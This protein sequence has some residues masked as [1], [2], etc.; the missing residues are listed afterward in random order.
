VL[1]N[2]SGLRG[3]FDVRL[4]RYETTRL[5]FDREGPLPSAGVEV[6]YYPART[7]KAELAVTVDA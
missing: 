4:S 1:H 7:T 2:A 5:A 3:T 6:T